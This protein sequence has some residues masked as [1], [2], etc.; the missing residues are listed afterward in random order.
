MSASNG[1]ASGKTFDRR[2][3]LDKHLRSTKAAPKQAFEQNLGAPM[4]AHWDGVN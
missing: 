3:Q 4:L 1:A 2:N